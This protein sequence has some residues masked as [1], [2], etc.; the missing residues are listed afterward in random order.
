MKIFTAATVA[1]IRDLL[2]PTM[3][4]LR[5]IGLQPVLFGIA[6]GTVVWA[7]ANP[8]LL[9][10]LSENDLGHGQRVITLVFIGI[11]TIG[12][13][14]ALYQ[15][16]GKKSRSL[17]GSPDPA[18]LRPIYRQ[19]RFLLAGPLV[20]AALTPKLAVTHPKSTAVLI[21]GAA[22]L[23]IPSIDEWQQRI[24]N[25]LARAKS[26]ATTGQTTRWSG[27]LTAYLPAV[28]VGLLWLG[29]A[30]FL[31]HLTVTT[32]HA[33]G[34]RTW[35]LAIYDNIFFH[36]SQGN[37]LGCSM[38][39]NGY[40]STAHFDPI[41]V[42]LSPLYHLWPRAETL[43]VLQ[44]VWCG[45]G[46]VPAFLLGRHHLK[47]PWAGV[48]LAA[49]YALHPALHGANVLDFHSM[50]LIVS[51]LL[52]AIYF[53]ETGNSR[54]YYLLL[55][56]MLLIR[57]DI[58]VLLC[59][60]SVAAIATRRPGS[61]RV[62]L[63]TIG[64]SLAYVIVVKLVFMSS[65]DVFD[66]GQRG[67][68]YARYY[69]YV[70][71]NKGGVADI[72]LSLVTNPVHVL[73]HLLIEAKI[74]YLLQ[75]FGPL[76]FLPFIAPYGRIAMGY[77]LAVILLASRSHM[78][79]THYQYTMVLLPVL[80]A[81]LPVALKRLAKNGWQ[82]LIPARRSF[83]LSCLGGVLVASVLLSMKFGVLVD[84]HEF[85]R[86]TR[87]MTPELKEQYAAVQRMVA[88]IGP[89]ASVQAS[90]ALSSHA[91]NRSRFYGLIHHQPEEPVDYHLVNL[92]RLRPKHKRAYRA[93]L[94]S[95]EL[96]EVDSYEMIKLYKTVRPL[97]TTPT[98]E[99]TTISPPTTHSSAARSE[100]SPPAP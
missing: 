70:I 82:R 12:I 2:G 46:V 51:P 47:S 40:H 3:E 54:G 74:K 58:S 6:I 61:L 59:A 29:Y 9:T 60:V 87:R 73:R 27:R 13:Y 28:L 50:T 76:L 91:S 48:A 67:Y 55:P 49:V 30:A 14:A 35:D 23:C 4:R 92:K 81:L 93:K 86:L 8:D 36:S 72:L 99:A 37:P 75:V 25:Q 85:S 22:L 53:L 57:E 90:E 31:S 20:V 17:G 32:Y 84:N 15:L 34:T 5:I 26:P 68:D 42:L 52:L 79:S 11:A 16:V 62:G 19:W 97:P 83:A 7:L 95:G 38:M 18:F 41:L 21:I 69:R 80:I 56:F 44:S 65:T 63:I 94:K 1:R 71:P 98:G 88:I 43:L 77:G 66:T 78:Y 10:L 33:L 64:V 100:S 24:A 89:D 45:F 96:V 39:R